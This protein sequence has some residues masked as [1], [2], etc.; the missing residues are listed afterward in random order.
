MTSLPI[1]ELVITCKKCRMVQS[2][3]LHV[4][5]RILT[6]S[7]GCQL[8]EAHECPVCHNQ[9]YKL[10]GSGLYCPA[11]AQHSVDICNCGQHYLS[12]HRK[13]CKVCGQK[14][15]IYNDHCK[16]CRKHLSQRHEN[17]CDVCEEIPI[18]K[19]LCNIPIQEGL[20]L[21]I[22]YSIKKEDHDGY[23]S[24]AGADNHE[25]TVSEETKMFP[26]PK[27]FGINRIDKDN[28]DQIKPNN[29]NIIKYYSIPSRDCQKGSG[30]C[31]MGTTY[32]IKSVKV[33]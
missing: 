18:C 11:C 22:T 23:C 9:F 7:C 20:Q 30:Y 32:S 16:N 29:V 8:V 15:S 28:E 14:Y 26:L 13:Q 2:L 21:K 6:C 24:D 27:M 19:L 4:E 12:I 1:N 5:N 25:I 31:E 33:I 17:V 10:L 3:P